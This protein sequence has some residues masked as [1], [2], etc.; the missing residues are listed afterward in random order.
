MNDLVDIDISPTK[1]IVALGTY[2]TRAIIFS[3][4]VTSVD[5]KI[6]KKKLTD[7]SVVF[8]N[9]ADNF[10]RLLFIESMRVIK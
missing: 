4:C 1:H 3:T 9:V 2:G 8:N 5:N 7:T 6:K 10:Y